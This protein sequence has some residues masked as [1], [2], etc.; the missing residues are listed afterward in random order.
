MATS[1]KKIDEGFVALVNRHRPML[2]RVCRIYED[3]PEE[4]K[5]LFQEVVYQVW[6]SYPTYRGEASLKTWMYRVALNTAITRFRQQAARP[7]H[8]ELQEDMSTGPRGGKTATEDQGRTEL[9]YCAIRSLNRVDRAVVT[10]YLEG[11]EYREI[12]ETLGLSETNVGVKL[13]RIRARLQEWM[14]GQE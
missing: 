6:R 8:V 13:N 9:L 3:G 12:A 2:E 7:E 10:L 11:F 1:A 4:R 5:D 14:R